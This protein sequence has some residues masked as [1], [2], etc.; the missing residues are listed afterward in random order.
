MIAIRAEN[1]SKH[2]RIYASPMERLKEIVLRRPFHKVFPALDEIN[3][4]ILR[5]EAVGIIGENGA[6]KSTLLKILSRTLKPTSGNLE[7]NGRCAA[8]LEL[9]AGFNPELNGEE[10]IY[11]NAYLLGLTKNEIDERKKDI[12]AF[13]EL[14]D[15]ISQPVKTY[16]SGMYVRLAF[17]IATS[18]NP[19]IL[20]IDEALAVGDQRFQKKCVDRMVSFRENGKTILF[21]SHSM[22]LV[23]TLCK[24]AIW[25][26]KGRIKMTGEADDVTRAYEDW[27]MEK[28][29]QY[30][31]ES[32][33]LLKRFED[34]PPPCRVLSIK[35]E[36]QNGHELS[37]ITRAFDTIRLV[38]E[39][40]AIHDADVHFGF[41]IF[42]TDE[43]LCFC[44]LTTFDGLPPIHLKEGEKCLISLALDGV[45]LVDGTYKVMGGIADEHGLHVHHASYSAPFLVRYREKH[46]IGVVTWPRKWS[47]D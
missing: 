2:Y 36:D 7:I 8:L 15:F 10:N 11:L 43:L 34:T 46:G 19:D 9:G 39:I 42:R 5:G 33:N 16:S 28:G 37:K 35:L 38:M 21:C 27:S 3:F 13:S 6:G 29:K 14:Q 25:I 24:R 26:D 47:F 4:E 12:I 44:S 31:T 17:S 45:S 20:I 22:Y 18:V 1:I 23:Q 41:A 40:Q 32:Q 30:E